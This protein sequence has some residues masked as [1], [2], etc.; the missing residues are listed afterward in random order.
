MRYGHSNEHIVTFLA[1]IENFFLSSCAGYDWSI[2]DIM[3]NGGVAKSHQST[4][5]QVLNNDDA[6]RDK[7][8]EN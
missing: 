5:N 2:N 8:L 7:G 3:T 6:K 1:P 4:W